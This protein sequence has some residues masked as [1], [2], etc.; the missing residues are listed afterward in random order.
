MCAAA[1]SLW[2]RARDLH[3]VTVTSGWVRAQ[4]LTCRGVLSR[5]VLAIFMMLLMA[6]FGSLVYAFEVGSRSER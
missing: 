1:S 5:R 6:L 2:A 3:D 4:I